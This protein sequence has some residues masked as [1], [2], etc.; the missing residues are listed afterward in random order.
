M[1]DKP[2][3]KQPGECCDKNGIPIHRGDLPKT[4][5]F[6][7]PRRKRYYLYHV[8]VRDEDAS[9]MRMMPVQYLDPG[10]KREGGM[11]LLSDDLA[12][13]AEVIDGMIVGDAVLY[14]ERK[15]RKAGE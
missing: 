1:S 15:K 12:A 6:T 9:A 7:G 8:A 3:L 11:P 14:D 2:W 4:P 10:V 13:N 5:H